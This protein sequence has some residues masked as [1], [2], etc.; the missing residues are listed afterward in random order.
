MAVYRVLDR[1][2]I[3]IALMMLLVYPSVALYWYLDSKSPIMELLDTP[4]VAYVTT[5]GVAIE[6]HLKRKTWCTGKVFVT[7]ISQ[8]SSHVES[9]GEY[10]YILFQGEM[11]FVRLY[12]TPRLPRGKWLLRFNLETYC[13]PLYPNQ[14]IIEVPFDVKDERH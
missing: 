6:W 10:S 12:K 14:Q 1:H 11:R 5:E 7:A 2:I 8:S 13:N 4:K 9:L 3:L